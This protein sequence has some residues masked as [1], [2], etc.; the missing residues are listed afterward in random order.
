MNEDNNFDVGNTIGT[1][2]DVIG[3]TK[4]DSENVSGMINKK[5]SRGG[6]THVSDNEVVENVNDLVD[7]A[8][9]K[10]EA[11]S[12]KLPRKTIFG[13]A[14]LIRLLGGFEFGELDEDEIL[15]PDDDMARYMSSFGG[16]QQLEADDFDFSDGY[17]A[18]VYDLPW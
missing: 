16:G 12:K 10:V 3:S 2:N 13:L 18:Q 17:E 8:R 6:H 4:L 14:N 9:K 5:G 7:D 11:P 1:F 15:E